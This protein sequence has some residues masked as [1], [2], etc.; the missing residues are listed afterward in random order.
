MELEE[1]DVV[2]CTVDRIVGTTVFVKMHV[3]GGD[4]EG[5]IVTSEIAAGRIRNLR[6]YV[7]PKKKIVC[8]ILR[9]SGNHIDLSLRRVTQKEQKEVMEE[10]KLEKSYA[11]ILK[12]I[13][14]EK[15]DEAIKKIT[16]EER[17]YD[18]FENAKEDSKK[19]EKLVGKEN[20]KKILEI[21]N[22]QKQKNF[23]VKR[24]I[25]LRTT[26]PNGVETVKSILG[27]AEGVEVKYISAGRYSL[28][29]EAGDIKTADTVLKNILS[30][31][32]KAAKKEGA[33]FSV[34]ENKSQ[35]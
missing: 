27:K 11:S 3:S 2:L 32:E 31:I 15:T 34:V 16:E 14:K 7:V 5:S 12:T 18:F 19:L 29:S 33:E 26:K 20:S 30:E 1:G 35:K 24:E 8:K 22:S 6:D 4:R 13:L 25:S 23:I 9:I 21:I 17:L 28:K 10:Y